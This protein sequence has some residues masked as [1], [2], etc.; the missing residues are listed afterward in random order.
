MIAIVVL[1]FFSTSI[2]A[3]TAMAGDVR[4]A[5]VLSDEPQGLILTFG[6]RVLER[7]DPVWHRTSRGYETQ[8]SFSTDYVLRYKELKLSGSDH[9][10]SHWHQHHINYLRY[11]NIVKGDPACVGGKGWCAIRGL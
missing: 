7:F 6:T 4:T 8:I 9:G 2:V 5:W 11:S 10:W 3:N 1:A